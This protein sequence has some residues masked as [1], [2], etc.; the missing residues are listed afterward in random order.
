MHTGS[1]LVYNNGRK[2]RN[3]TNIFCKEDL[4]TI[5]MVAY[6]PKNSYLTEVVNEKIGIVHNAG[7]IDIWDR[8]AQNF[9]QS[10]VNEEK[11]LK[12]INLNDLKAI[13]LIYLM[14]AAVGIVIFVWELIHKSLIRKFKHFTVH[15][16]NLNA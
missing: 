15:H 1:L 2:D 16:V 13:F 3:F 7:L 8:Q 12:D 11:T 6:L 5:S 9:T 10:I 14:A 4:M